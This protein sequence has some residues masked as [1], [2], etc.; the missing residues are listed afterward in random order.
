MTLRNGDIESLRNRAALDGR[1]MKSRTVID[2]QGNRV[3]F[4]VR[5]GKVEITGV[6]RKQST[7]KSRAI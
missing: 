2:Q 1:P 7:E 4:T 3:H 6:N 5:K